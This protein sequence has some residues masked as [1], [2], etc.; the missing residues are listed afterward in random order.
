MCMREGERRREAVAYVVPF[1]G[2]GVGFQGSGVDMLPTDFH[3]CPRSG[4][5]RGRRGLRGGGPM[6]SVR[7]IRFIGM[8]SGSV[9]RSMVS[10]TISMLGGGAM[11]HRPMLDVSSFRRRSCDIGLCNINVLFGDAL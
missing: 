9:V 2:E 3:V 8:A 10:M 6:I 11:H 7:S 1:P 4:A 5:R